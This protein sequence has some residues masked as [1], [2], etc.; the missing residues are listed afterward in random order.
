MLVKSGQ[1]NY[2]DNWLINYYLPSGQTTVEIREGTV[3]IADGKLTSFQSEVTKV[4]LPSTLKY[5]GASN[6]QSMSLLTD[7]S[8]PA[9]LVS[10]GADAFNNCRA[11]TGVDLAACSGLRSIGE[12]AFSWC[13]S[14]TSLYI[15]SSVEYIGDSAFNQIKGLTLYIEREQNE[16]PSGWDED[17]DFTYASEP[18]GIVWGV[19]KPE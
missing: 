6:F 11:L 17:W 7:I 18:I 15:P 8:L 19:S 1:T 3:G 13:S 5:I 4:Q 2:I 14:I 10:I 12:T 9:G 16:I